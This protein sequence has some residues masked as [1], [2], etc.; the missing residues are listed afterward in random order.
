MIYDNI[1]ID[2]ANLF[3]RLTG[4]TDSVLDATKKIISFI[5]EESMKHLSKDG[6][7]YIVFDPISKNK[8][9]EEK[10]FHVQSYSTRKTIDKNYKAKRQY[11]KVY[12]QTIENILK[13][14]AYRGEKIK[15]VYSQNYEADDFIEPLVKTLNG[16]IALVSNDEDWSKAISETCFLINRGY[17]EPWSKKD[18]FEKYKFMPTP[19]ANI[20]YKSFFGDSSDNIQGCIFLKKAKFMTNIRKTCLNVIIDVSN[21]NITIDEFVKRFNG[22]NYQKVI[23]KEEKSNLET[24]FLEFLVANQRENVTGKMNQNIQLVRSLLDGK[25]ISK[26]IHFN[27][28]NKKFNDIIRQSIYGLDGKSWFGKVS[29]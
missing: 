27:P 3:Y 13:F 22:L 19:A 14:F 12:Y 18:F 21:E 5:N 28:E 7:I 23:E 4:K 8:L 11:S 1:I 10:S 6:T 16:N 25:D 26:Y 15:E 2:S 17:D 24:L 20:L 9:N 29:V